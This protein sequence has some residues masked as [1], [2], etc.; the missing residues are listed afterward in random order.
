MSRKIS[1]GLHSALYELL[2]LLQKYYSET[3]EIGEEDFQILFE[4]YNYLWAVLGYS[5]LLTQPKCD[6][7]VE[8]NI[9]GDYIEPDFIA[10]NEIRDQWEIVDLKLPKRSLQLSSRKRRKRFRSEIEDYI[11]QVQEYSRYFD[12]NDHREYVRSEH[13]VEIPPSPPVVLVLGSDLNQSEINE[14]LDRYNHDISIIQYDKILQLL[15]K[16]FKEK[17]GEEDGLPG[18]TVSS[19]ITLLEEPE[20]TR[21]YIIDIGKSLDSE[22]L[23]L[24]LTNKNE[25]T[26]EVTPKSGLSIDVSVPWKNALE[27]GEQK[28]LYVEFASSE[29][30][31]FARVFAGSE[32]LDEML[33]TMEL[34][35]ADI[36]SGSGFDGIGD[37][38][39][40]YLGADQNG[41]NG[42]SFAMHELTI[43]SKAEEIKERL[44]FMRYLQQRTEDDHEAVVFEKNEY[45][46]TKDSSDIHFPNKF[47]INKAENKSQID[48]YID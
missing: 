43:L 35:F 30:L 36:E 31:S 19:R 40:L 14:Q 32:I 18:L 2:N 5:S 10:Y 24:Y 21:E 4:N 25:L 46:Y 17:S 8:Q 7:L 41:E 1:D 29:N 44:Q 12:E 26:L 38:F 3:D 28:V 16:E 6:L 45:G 47:D 23:C 15:E 20:N 27:I 34:P 9:E 13:D 48:N 37:E 33:L 22:R 11:V 39:D 42:A